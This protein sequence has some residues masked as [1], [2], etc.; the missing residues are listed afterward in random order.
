MNEANFAAASLLII[1]EVLKARQD[2]RF[3]MFPFEFETKEKEAPL[4]GEI[5]AKAEEGK[6]R[7]DQA[8]SDDDDEERFVDV[9]KYA[10]SKSAPVVQSDDKKR[11]ENEIYDPLKREPK[12]ARAESCLMF[13]LTALCRHSHPTVRLWAEKVLDGK[14]VDYSGDPLLDFSI[15]NFLDRIAYKEPKSQEKLAK[16][17]ERQRMSNFSK[18]LN[19]IDFNK[20]EMPA[21]VREEERFMYKYLETKEKKGKE[22]LVLG[23]DS[24]DADL[25]AFADAEI[26]KEMKRLQSGAGIAD[27]EDDDEADV[28]YSD[29][30]S[31]GDKEMK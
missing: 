24:E 13:E 10:E 3:Q 12:Y 21:E 28:S 23:S 1:S 31:A 29:D 6:V 26:R 18:P 19:Q 27:G 20:G 9:D 11:T 30:G 25:E 2:I 4:G 14:A 8:G 5:K 17:Q 16:F 7:L 15:A 22:E